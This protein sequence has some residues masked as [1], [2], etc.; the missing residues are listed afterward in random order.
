MI[1]VLQKPTNLQK[2]T[3]QAERETKGSRRRVSKAQI[4]WKHL[5]SR[6][7]FVSKRGKNHSREPGMSRYCTRFFLQSFKTKTMTTTPLLTPC[8][9][10]PSA[11]APASALLLHCTNIGLATREP[12]VSCTSCLI[13]SLSWGFQK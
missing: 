9:P 12:K 3:I 5:E 7:H 4:S 1:S 13:R 10:S 11:Q 2:I 6:Y 8:Q